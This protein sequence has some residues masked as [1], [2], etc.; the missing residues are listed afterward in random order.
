[1]RFARTE[2][3]K[4][5]FREGPILFFAP[6]EPI[7]RPLEEAVL[8]LR[9]TK[10]RSPRCLFWALKEKGLFEIEGC[11]SDEELDR[12]ACLRQAA[13]LHEC[14]VFWP[15]RDRSDLR[16][17]SCRVDPTQIPSTQKMEL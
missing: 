10:S 11:L 2:G 1:M 6:T 15:N 3:E 13:E 7:Q 8:R 4:N 5:E 9:A 14:S 16:K 12:F 17:R